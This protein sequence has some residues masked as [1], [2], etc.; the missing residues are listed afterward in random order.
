MPASGFTWYTTQAKLSSSVDDLY[1]FSRVVYSVKYAY[2]AVV[3]FHTATAIGF[4]TQSVTD[5]FQN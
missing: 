3:Y 2:A 5:K 1:D 4:L